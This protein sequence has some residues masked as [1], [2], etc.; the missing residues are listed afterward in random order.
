MNSEA[1]IVGL[2]AVLLLS[3]VSEAK[4]YTDPGSGALLWQLLLGAA[5]GSLFYFRRFVDWF[6]RFRQSKFGLTE[7]SF[8][9]S[10]NRGR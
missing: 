2:V 7:T 6:T 10:E 9:G 5:T 1:R 8:S 3:S 4:A